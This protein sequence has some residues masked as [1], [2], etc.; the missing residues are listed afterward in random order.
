MCRLLFFL[1]WAPGLQVN[2]WLFVPLRKSL[3]ISPLTESLWL[4]PALWPRRESFKL[5][6][7]W[8]AAN[9]R[10]ALCLVLDVVAHGLSCF[11]ACD[12]LL[13]NRVETKMK[14]K[15]VHDVLNRLHLA[16][17]AKR[18]EKVNIQRAAASHFSCLFQSI[19]FNF[20]SSAISRRGLRSSL[21]EPW[22]A[23]R[24]WR[25]THPNAKRYVWC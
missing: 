25:W 17:P 5:K 3:P 14:G 24:R 4:R 20:L 6:M 18:D 22:C 8:D 13:A 9:F 19:C 23:G 1:W 21:K 12:R 10:L 16:M 2:V 15:K 7:R 11:Q